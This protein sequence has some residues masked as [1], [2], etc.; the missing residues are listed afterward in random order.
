[1]VHY[2]LYVLKWPLLKYFFWR[3][4]RCE[5]IPHVNK[6][7][8]K[9]ST[10]TQKAVWKISTRSNDWC[11]NIRV[12][13]KRCRKICHIGKNRCDK[14]QHTHRKRCE[15]IYTLAKNGVKKIGIH[16]KNGVKNW[17]HTQKKVWRNSAR[18]QSARKVRWSC[19]RFT[20]FIVNTHKFD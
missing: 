15:K 4:K 3:Q 10:R 20:N 11:D 1:M 19:Y 13:K 8:R 9:N 18:I 16:V 7:V 6:M 2:F 5:K 12:F 17:A 14:F